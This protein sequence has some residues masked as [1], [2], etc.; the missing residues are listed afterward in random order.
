MSIAI[1]HRLERELDK[2]VRKSPQLINQTNSLGNTPL[3][4]AAGW[5]SGIRKLLQHGACLDATD[6]YGYI[7]IC[8]AIDMG[9]SETVS[10]LMKAGCRLYFRSWR[11]HNL[12]DYLSRHLGHTDPRVWSVSQEAW[13]N[14]LDTVISLLAERRR[15]L[16]SR[17]A[18]LSAAFTINPKVFQADRVLD[19]YAEYAECV[20]EDA[21]IGR[22]HMPR[23]ESSLLPYC[24]TVYHIDRLTVEV[25]EKLWQNGFRDI[26]VPDE[27]GLTPL[28]DCGRSNGDENNLI[29]EIEVIS[30]LIQKG[31]KLHRLQQRSLDY[32]ANPTISATEL[33]LVTRALHY[34]AY[35]IGFSARVFLWDEYFLE[36]ERRRL[37]VELHRLSKEAKL[38]VTT[39]Y[40]D[41]SYDDCICA[42][43]FQGCLAS[44]MMLKSFITSFATWSFSDVG[45][46]PEKWFPLALE[47]LIDL[48]GPNEPWPDW[49][50]KEIIRYR[51]FIELDLRHTCCH[52]ENRFY[53]YECSRKSSEERAEIRDEDHE[54][55]ELL[56]SLLLEFEEQRGTQD[57]L[58]FLE[59]YWS[60][61]MD[62]VRRERGHVDK[63]ALREMGVVLHEVDEGGSGE[64]GHDE[65]GNDEGG[66]D[67][68]RND[69]EESDGALRD[70]AP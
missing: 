46:D 50:V 48:I 42:C 6:R 13:M 9:N 53:S 54:K 19:E 30:W 47:Y 5:P 26:D 27:R 34:V 22:E 32:D 37:Q 35:N 59:G 68:K 10:L 24:R 65:E 20:E 45:E 70:H 15:N 61:R 4:L 64:G 60:T 7:P 29:D 56:E 25:A 55:I 67:E 14:V 51:T 40:L 38:L 62:Q 66:N 58:S 69:E 1:G 63:V 8:Y 33:P 16:Q 12:L 23:H 17:L 39:V 44:T 28:M 21:M 31:A 3:H 52:I 18:A 43:S 41:V 2:A 36:L 49:L 57:V 11:D